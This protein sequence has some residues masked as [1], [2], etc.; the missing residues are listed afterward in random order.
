MDKLTR[1]DRSIALPFVSK[2][3]P[4][5]YKMSF[6]LA[7][8]GV[9]VV[10]IKSLNKTMAAIFAEYAKGQLVFFKYS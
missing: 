9:S 10:L 7:L 3:C 5:T 6:V 8:G 2:E 1:Q 4:C